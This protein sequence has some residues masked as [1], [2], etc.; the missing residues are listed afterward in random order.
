MIMK[1]DSQDQ[2]RL[3]QLVDKLCQQQPLR[4]APASLHERVMRQVQ[5]RKALPWWRQSFM[6]WPLMLQVAFVVT[7]LGTAKL[8]LSVSDWV[9][10]HWLASAST[11][12]QSSSLVQGA[13]TI[14][15]VTSKVTSQIANMVPTSWIYGAALLIGMLYLVLFGIG[16]ATYRTL[17]A[18]RIV[19]R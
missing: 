19:A 9:S 12:T 18:T 4:R 8:A 3:E 14:L 7:A 13:S 6:N 15:A 17:Y 2:K 1:P 16:V 10:S 11:A 5:L